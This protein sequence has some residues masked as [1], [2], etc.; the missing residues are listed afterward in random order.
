MLQGVVARGVGNAR[1]NADQVPLAMFVHL[2]PTTLAGSNGDGYGG[3]VC[4]GAFVQHLFSQLGLTSSGM[5]PSMSASVAPLTL[6]T[7]PP[8]GRNAS[9]QGCLQNCVEN[10]AR[11]SFAHNNRIVRDIH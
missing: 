3:D 4:S 5:G 8:V 1:S 11:L 10:S 7:E 6:G 9:P 2:V